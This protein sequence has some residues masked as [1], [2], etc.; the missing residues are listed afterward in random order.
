MII[1]LEG[2]SPFYA[3]YS[4]QADKIDAIIENAIQDSA[5]KMGNLITEIYSFSAIPTEEK[6]VA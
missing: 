4:C 6:L 2:L 1:S 5:A 3:A